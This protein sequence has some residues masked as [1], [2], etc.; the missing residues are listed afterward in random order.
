MPVKRLPRLR[1]R[2]MLLSL[3]VTTWVK[4]RW[5]KGTERFLHIM[6]ARR[7]EV[8]VIQQH[9]IVLKL[10]A[11][12]VLFFGVVLI[13]DN[14][15]AQRAQQRDPASVVLAE[16]ERQPAA[17]S[18]DETNV[19]WV[20]DSRSAIHR[21][22]K[23]GGAITPVLTGQEGIRRMIVDGD[24]IYFLTNKQIKQV[25]K[26]GGDATTLITFADLGPT[27]ISIWRL[28]VDKNNI[29]FVGGPKDDQLLK[30]SRAG[31]KPMPLAQVFI[32]SNFVSDGVN[33][34]WADS[35]SEVKKVNVAGGEPITIGEC[36]K[37]GAVAVDSTSVYCATEAGKVMRFAKRDGAMTTLGSLEQVSFDQLSVD[38]RSVYALS[39]L[40]GIYRFDKRGGTPAKLVSINGESVNF[41]VD[42][43]DLFWSNYS[44]G[45][46]MRRR[47]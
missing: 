3:L 28:A 13:G 2:K 31:G 12:F 15:Q 1:P 8:S 24:S 25:R 40:S 38:E 42:S 36:E 21:V 17:I 33:I 10:F 44:Q 5:L 30:L 37:A 20:A 4:R 16:N 34:Y 18:V 43:H 9:K 45:T 47:K 7:G 32:P 6:F 46:V 27:E 11:P 19:Y 41:V 39:I 14:G 26:T 35:Q 23:T 22:S 29:Y